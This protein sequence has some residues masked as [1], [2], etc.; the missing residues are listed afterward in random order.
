MFA[1]FS[2][3]TERKLHKAIKQA[4]NDLRLLDAK[5]LIEKSHHGCFLLPSSRVKLGC[6]ETLFY[7][8]EGEFLQAYNSLQTL[9]LLPL[10]PYERRAIDVEMILLLFIS[11][12]YKATKQTLERLQKGKL[13]KEE[14]FTCHQIQANLYLVDSNY[15]AAKDLIEDLLLSTQ[16]TPNMQVKLLHNLAVAE[17]HQRNYQG[18]MSAY[19]K[20]WNIQKK[21]ENNF[22]QAE[23]T[24]D[25]LVQTYAKQDEVV[26]IQVFVQQLETLADSGNINHLLALNNINLNLARQL[27][28][29]Q[30]LLAT[31]QRADEKLLPK[32][33][34]ELRFTY[35]VN[36][37]RMHWNDRVN[38]DSAL[39]GVME[40]TLYHRSNISTLNTLRSIKEVV[41]T[42]MQAMER[43]GP[44]PDLMVFYNW[45]I[46]EFK[47]LE[48]K[49]DQLLDEIPPNL[50]ASKSELIGFKIDSIK[51]GF[52]YQKPSEVL[53]DRLFDLLNE[54]RN[55]WEGMHNTAAQL[56]EIVTVL[57]EYNAFE[58]RLKT[59]MPVLYPLF[60]R[61]FKPM[62][63][64]ALHDAEQLIAPHQQHLAYANKLIALAY[65]CYKIDTKKEQA[66]Q[67]LEAFDE[68]ELS[69]EHSAVWFRDQYKRTKIWVSSI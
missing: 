9:K 10:L 12:N 49:I 68:M 69:L 55:L 51:Y 26:E 8:E 52:S 18:A 30:V 32:L 45:L 19:R 1:F 28:D 35:L 44:R 46:L 60:V 53:F 27:G 25:N 36:S 42:L 67:W 29:R 14:E 22:A 31:Y 6:L 7:R 59:N 61:K 15:Q 3:S 2:S 57:D 62:A 54:K 17:T 40:A 11:G 43:I 5:R 65:A 38:F 13:S 48:P 64:A 66:K 63:L 56:N 41:G 58:R 39:K 34:G 20:A 16:L 4:I 50:P 21:F 33:G 24:I 37:L 47:R 23:I